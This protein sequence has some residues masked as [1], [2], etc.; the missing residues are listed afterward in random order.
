MRPLPPP[1][2]GDNGAANSNANQ[3]M[4]GCFSTLWF[5]HF[6][7]ATN[8]NAPKRRWKKT[9]RPY[10]RQ[11]FVS[12]S[13]N[14]MHCKRQSI[15]H[16]CH[17][18]CNKPKQTIC[19]NHFKSSETYLRPSRQVDNLVIGI[20]AQPSQY[21]LCRECSPSAS[22][23][24][25]CWIVAGKKGSRESIRLCFM[26]HEMCWRRHLFQFRDANS[27]VL[28]FKLEAIVQN[29]LLCAS[30]TCIC[31]LYSFLLHIE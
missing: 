14:M 16:K 26:P 12:C 25:W 9:H 31:L 15:L 3:Y 30:H 4:L 27:F 13:F 8:A 5:V 20:L 10:Y 29:L 6:L 1:H 18:K 17:E 22:R 23:Q 28:R 19:I 11:R 24:L 2:H 21:E 7:F